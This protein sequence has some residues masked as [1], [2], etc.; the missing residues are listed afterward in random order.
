MRVLILRPSRDLGR[1]AAAW[2]PLALIRSRRYGTSKI[3]AFRTRLEQTERAGLVDRASARRASLVGSSQLQARLVKLN[4][5]TT[6]ATN[7]QA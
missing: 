6:V 7:G 5:M 3:P 2:E 4:C 1:L